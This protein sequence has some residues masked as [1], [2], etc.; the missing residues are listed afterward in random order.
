MPRSVRFLRTKEGREVD[1]VLAEGETPRL[2]IEVKYG[3]REVSP[4]LVYF[5][6]RYPMEALQLVADLRLEYDSRGVS[7]R[8]AE[9]W[10][11]NLEI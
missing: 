2:M 10:L 3:D 7:V 1:F 11:S 6:E 8:R 5:R 9:T 4:H